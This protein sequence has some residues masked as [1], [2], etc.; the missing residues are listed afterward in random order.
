MDAS[1][2]AVAAAGQTVGVIYPLR[3]QLDENAGYS[4]RGLSLRFSYAESGSPQTLRDAAIDLDSCDL[5]V[6]N[7]VGFT[8]QDRLT[9]AQQIGKPV[10][11]ARRRS[12]ARRLGKECVSTCRTR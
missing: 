9:I 3:R 7:S 6:L 10:I 1:I 8:E 5:V 12:E 2:E 11:L 4:V